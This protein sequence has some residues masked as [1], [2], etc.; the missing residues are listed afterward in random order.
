MK[1][2]EYLTENNDLIDVDLFNRDI[3]VDSIYNY[4]IE[5]ENTSP[6]KI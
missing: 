1:I 6:I 2:P 5:N 3:I 4:I